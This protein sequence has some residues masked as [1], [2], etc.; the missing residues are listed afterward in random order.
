[1]NNPLQQQGQPQMQPQAAMAP[2]QPAQPQMG[3]QKAPWFNE[4]VQQTLFGRIQALSE[5]EVAILDSIVTQET[6][7]VL[8][9]VFT[10]LFSDGTEQ[11]QPQGAIQPQQPQQPQQGAGHAGGASPAPQGGDNTPNPLVNRDVSRGLVG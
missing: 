4:E 1:M 8:S 2:E 11:Q 7:P 3:G 5:Q 6:F 10:E 9:K